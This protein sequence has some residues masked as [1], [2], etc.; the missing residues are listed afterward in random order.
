[1]TLLIHNAAILDSTGRRDHAWI[2]ISGAFITAIGSDDS[3][4]A[5]ADDEVIDAQGQ[6]LVPGFIDLHV[7]GG[8]GHSFQDDGEAISKALATHRVSGTTRSLISLVTT[9]LEDLT[10]QLDL[11]STLKAE[12]RLILGAHLEGPFL[13]PSQKGAHNPEFLVHPTVDNTDHLLQAANGVIRQITIAPELPGADEAIKGFVDAGI[14][15]AIGHTDVDFEGA[16]RAFDLGARLLTHGF[17][18]M[19]G[20]H[21]RSPG[22]VLAAF[23]DDRITVEL[24]AD[25]IHVDRHVISMAFN[26]ARH[27][28]ALVTDAMAAAGSHDGTYS[29]GSLQVEVTGNRVVL[30]G[31]ETIAGSTLTQDAALAF[32]IEIA[33]IQPS[34]AIAALT[35][36]PARVLGLDEELGLI[37]V[38][39]RADVVLLDQNW[40]TQAVWAD[41]KSLIG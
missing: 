7:H 40:R 39:Y 1:M 16:R 24:I 10:R 22:P 12:D 21:H 15:V 27:R 37:S 6:W 36:V 2:R 9:P 35:Q 31:T 3:W 38:G 25:G 20:I 17:N 4:R 34:T 13:S 30:A 23:D 18:A 28:V 14:V 29:L 8:G 33:G 26:Q 5:A 11:I 32:A 19:R 41:G